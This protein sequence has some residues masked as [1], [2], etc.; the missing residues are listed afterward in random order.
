[1]TAT[2]TSETT[3]EWLVTLT[4]PVTNT[5]AALWLSDDEVAVLLRLAREIAGMATDSLHPAV[6]LTR[7]DEATETQR[8][9]LRHAE[10]ERLLAAL[11]DQIP[12]LPPQEAIR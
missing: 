4:G 1:M 9:Y 10:R 3:T 2:T 12:D 8:R 7:M 5:Y 11:A 6:R